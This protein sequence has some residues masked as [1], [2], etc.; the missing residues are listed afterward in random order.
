MIK[1][2]NGHLLSKNQYNLLSPCTEPVQTTFKT[3]DD[4]NSYLLCSLKMRYNN[5][6]FYYHFPALFTFYSDQEILSENT[7]LYLNRVDVGSKTVYEH[8]LNQPI[9]LIALNYKS[10]QEVLLATYMENDHTPIE[11]I[12]KKKDHMTLLNR[13]CEIGSTGFV[14]KFSIRTPY[15]ICICNPQKITQK[16]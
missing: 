7:K 1:L 15:I 10:N 14:I 9:D 13:L 16:L 12:I 6:L 2:Q 3:A 8:Q 4:Y 11:N 5:N